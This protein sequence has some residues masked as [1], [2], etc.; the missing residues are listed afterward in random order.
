MLDSGTKC[1]HVS[2]R[3]GFALAEHH[4]SAPQAKDTVQDAVQSG[5]PAPSPIE[6][7]LILSPILLYGIFSLYR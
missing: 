2:V 1:T 7:L 6:I 3:F 4:Q 5:P